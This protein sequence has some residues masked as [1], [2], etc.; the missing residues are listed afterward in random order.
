MLVIGSNLNLY[1]LGGISILAVVYIIKINSLCSKIKAEDAKKQEEFAK[2]A[3][4]D[5]EADKKDDEN[6]TSKMI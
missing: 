1:Q 3:V 5:E 6:K 2:V 4:N